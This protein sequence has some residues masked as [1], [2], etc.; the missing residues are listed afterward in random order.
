[1]FHALWNHEDVASMQLDGPGAS[2]G[3]PDAVPDL[4][5][6]SDCAAADDR[7]V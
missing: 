1:M 4:L 2:V 7:L 6:Y 5:V 3:I